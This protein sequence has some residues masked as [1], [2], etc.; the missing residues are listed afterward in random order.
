MYSFLGFILHMDAVVAEFGE[1]GTAMFIFFAI[2]LNVC[3]FLYDRL[4]YPLSM[5]YFNRIRPRL[6]LGAP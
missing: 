6:R 3:M 5:I 2:L 4:L 1:M